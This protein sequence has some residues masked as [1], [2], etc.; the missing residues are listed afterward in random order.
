MTN[1]DF[2][3]NTY[4]IR[5][6][7]ICL[8]RFVEEYVRQPEIVYAST[9]VIHM[10]DNLLQPVTYTISLVAMCVMVFSIAAR[11]AVCK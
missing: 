2:V 5:R 6:N 10:R 8:L 11:Y 1:D 3:F 7:L 4:T 9:A